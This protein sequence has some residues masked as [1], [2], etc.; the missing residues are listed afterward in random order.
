VTS[1]TPIVPVNLDL[2]ATA[3]TVITRAAMRARRASARAIRAGRLVPGPCEHCG[4]VE[5]IIG[6]HADYAEALAVTWLC[7]SCHRHHH[8]RAVRPLRHRREGSCEQ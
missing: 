7:D 8:N 3:V 2:S 1:N 6:H 5:S 4:T